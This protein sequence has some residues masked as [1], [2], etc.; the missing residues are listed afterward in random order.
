[1]FMKTSHS[2]RGHFILR[3]SIQGIPLYMYNYVEP[4]VLAFK[5]HFEVNLHLQVRVKDK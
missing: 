4:Q 2:S 5:T 1:M 3:K